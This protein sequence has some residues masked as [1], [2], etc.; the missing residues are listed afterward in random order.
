MEKFPRY[1]SRITILALHTD[2]DGPR[3][4]YRCTD[5]HGTKQTTHLDSLLV[6]SYLK[7]D[8]RQNLLIIME[9][10]HKFHKPVHIWSLFG[11]AGKRYVH[12]SHLSVITLSSSVIHHNVSIVASIFQ[13]LTEVRHDQSSP[14]TFD[15]RASWRDGGS[16]V[17][18]LTVGR[19]SWWI[20]R[21][22]LQHTTS[23]D[24][25]I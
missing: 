5:T 2:L 24:S 16:P 13:S 23:S 14:W 3:S 9:P 18:S 11:R 17:A 6:R 20:K 22:I 15:Q 7:N 8:L 1:A 21:L 19:T 4:Q 10:A 12:I 25:C